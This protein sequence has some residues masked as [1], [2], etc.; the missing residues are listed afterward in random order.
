MAP[1]IR[2]LALG[3]G[4]I[5]LL[6][7]AGCGH[8]LFPTRGYSTADSIPRPT[9][10]TVRPGN[11]GP[12]VTWTAPDSDFEIIEGWHVYRQRPDS[13]VT[14][15]TVRPVLRREFTD[16]EPAVNGR[17]EYWVTA[18]SR[19]GVESRA[20][21]MYPYVVDG[22]PPAT[23]VNLIAVAGPGRVTLSWSAGSEFDLFSY[24][25]YRDHGAAPFGEVFDRDI[26]SFLDFTVEPG[27]TYR[28]RVSAVDFQGLESPKSD[29]VSVTVP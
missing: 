21:S 14:R 6:A 22:L 29:E 9:G 3:A 18:M 25:I 20:S 28:Y 23:P 16:P 27:R 5:G 12:F 15:L 17:T 7:V 19:G 1:V 4:M 8:D 26:P 24:R 10:V 11:P 13:T 2:R